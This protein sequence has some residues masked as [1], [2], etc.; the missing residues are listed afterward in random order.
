MK[1]AQVL[2]LVLFAGLGA[3]AAA[4]PRSQ[5]KKPLIYQI[6]TTVHIN[7][8]GPRPLLQAVEALQERYGWLVNYEDPQYPPASGP[9][10]TMPHRLHSNSN[11]DASSFSVQFQVGPK[12]DSV[13]DEQTVLNAVVDAYNQSGGPGQFAVRKQEGG[14]LAVVGI[15][16]NSAVPESAS[17]TP[18]FDTS[19][20]LPVERHNLQA[21]VLLLCRALSDATRVTIKAELS[22]MEIAEKQI[23]AGGTTQPA[24]ALLAKALATSVPHLY[25]QLLFDDASRTYTL[26]IRRQK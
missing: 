16:V 18:V 2:S 8:Y 12:E 11:P 9:T 24:R 23:A 25:W 20:S 15:G 1:L 6:G 19:I 14:N 10:P 7:A 26:K 17:Q 22:Q 21:T 5:L 4:Q 3:G 13:P